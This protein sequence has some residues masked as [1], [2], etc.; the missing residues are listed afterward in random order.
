MRPAA[1]VPPEH[2]ARAQKVS[3]NKGYKRFGDAAN[4]RSGFVCFVGWLVERIVGTEE[5]PLRGAPRFAGLKNS[6]YK[7][8]EAEKK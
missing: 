1:P 5:A 3:K 7:N 6:W 8:N 2:Q 4:K